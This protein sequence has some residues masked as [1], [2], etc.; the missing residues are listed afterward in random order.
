MKYMT[1]KNGVSVYIRNLSHHFLLLP[2]HTGCD[3][4]NKPQPSAYI[5]ATKTTESSS[6]SYLL[7][8]TLQNIAVCT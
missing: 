2:S 3:G 1:L 4:I 8:T 6:S 7:G 5:S